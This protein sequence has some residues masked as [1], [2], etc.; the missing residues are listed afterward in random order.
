MYCLWMKCPSVFTGVFY[1][2]M[3]WNRGTGQIIFITSGKHLLCLSFQ[4]TREYFWPQYILAGFIPLTL[5]GEMSN[6][7]TYSSHD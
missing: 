2:E 1:H 7:L 4:R 6:V 3:L 5:Y